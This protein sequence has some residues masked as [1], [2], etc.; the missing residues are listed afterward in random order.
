M[1]NSKN[2]HPKILYGCSH[3]QEVVE[4]KKFQL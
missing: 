3:L 4:Y 2:H 1:E